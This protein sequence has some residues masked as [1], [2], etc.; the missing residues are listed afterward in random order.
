MEALPLGAGGQQGAQSGCSKRISWASSIGI[1]GKFARNSD[2][3]APRQTCLVVNPDVGLAVCVL[4][5]APAVRV[6]TQVSEA[7]L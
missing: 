3:Q 6:P 1:P 4:T 2:S 5:S 7:L